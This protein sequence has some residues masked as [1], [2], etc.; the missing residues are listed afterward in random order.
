MDDLAPAAPPRMIKV[1]QEMG[2]LHIQLPRRHGSGKTLRRNTLLLMAGIMPLA[3]CSSVLA[4]LLLPLLENIHPSLMV[5]AVPVMIVMS[6]APYFGFFF[7]IRRASASGEVVLSQRM[8]KMEGRK[9]MELPL[10]EVIDIEMIEDGDRGRLKFLTT[11]GE[12][13]LFDGLFHHEL[14]WLHQ[15]ISENTHRLRAQMQEDGHDTDVVAMPP[16]AITRLIRQ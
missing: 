14:S 15:A 2:S 12:I 1:R 3:T 4:N 13:E 10:E 16:E 11:H 8:L 9:A 5:L 7:A 6:F